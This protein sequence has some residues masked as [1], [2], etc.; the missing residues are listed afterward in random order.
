MAENETTEAE[1]GEGEGEATPKPKSKLP[2]I[3]G[4]VVVLMGGGGGA[5]FMVM[6]GGGG[7]AQAA[8]KPELPAS[9]LGKVMPLDSFIVNLNEAKSTRYLKV[10]VHVELSDESVEEVVTERMVLIRDRVLTYLS[11][12]G[13]DD[14]RG[15]EP[16][17]AIREMLVSRVNEAINM[18]SGV[19]SI[20]FAEFVVQ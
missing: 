20:L 1:E 15:E 5:A 13:I 8:E 9:E 14:V 7:S 18:D 6:G 17:E 4:A 3:I 2:L 16:K 11:G 12:L 19:R 10:T